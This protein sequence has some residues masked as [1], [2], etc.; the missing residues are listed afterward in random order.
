MTGAEEERQAT[1]V[2]ERLAAEGRVRAAARP[3]HRPPMRAGD[4]SE[5]LGDA[6]AAL[7]EEEPW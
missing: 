7:R 3:G 5:R 4:G 2:R 1:P 6:L